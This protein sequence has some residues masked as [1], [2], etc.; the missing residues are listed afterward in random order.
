MFTKG[1]NPSSLIEN[2]VATSRPF[3]WTA[4]AGI[5]YRLEKD[6]KVIQKGKLRARFRPASIFWPPYG[7]IYWPVGFAYEKYDLTDTELAPVAKAI[8]TKQ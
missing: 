4:I 3:Y 6:N 5:R 7:I 2:G 1:P 8:E